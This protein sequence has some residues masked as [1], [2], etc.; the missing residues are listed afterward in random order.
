MAEVTEI[1]EPNFGVDLPG[2]WEQ[3]Q[4]DE[5]G[6]LVFRQVEG[7]A[8]LT[9][10]LLGVR[11]MFAIADQKRLLEDYM[12]HRSRFEEGRSPTL[13]HGDTLARQS[14]DAFE[15]YWIGEDPAHER[16]VRHRVLLVDGL[17]ADFAYEAQ[18]V[19]ARAFAAEADA[20][21]ASA[22]ASV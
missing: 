3:A 8:S 9:V 11:P 19:E 4:S 1:R 17:L 12:S 7:P 18:G 22:T 6:T 15:G 21:L 2:Q 14:G 20:V 13:V 5:V 10:V 16:L